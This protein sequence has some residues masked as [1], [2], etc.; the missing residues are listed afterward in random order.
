MNSAKL[1]TDIDHFGYRYQ[2]N[3]YMSIFMITYTIYPKSWKDWRLEH[4]LQQNLT[5]I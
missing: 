3:I 1:D 2:P 5:F 4:L